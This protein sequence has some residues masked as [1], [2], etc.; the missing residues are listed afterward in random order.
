M[1]IAAIQLV[2]VIVAH[3]DDETL[4]A[5]GTILKHPLWNCF[6]VCLCRKNDANRAP[7]FFRAIKLLGAKGIMGNL[8]DG[9]KQTP[10]PEEKIEQLIMDLL[11]PIHFNLILTHNPTGEYTKHL[12]HEEVSRA[13]I[14]LWNSNKI[15]ANELMTFAYEDGNKQYYPRPV[16][17]AT[18]HET[19]TQE[20]FQRKYDLI[21]KIYR[22]RKEGWEAKTCPREESFWLF[23]KPFEA[24]QWLD[25]GGMV[26][27]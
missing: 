7:K 23:K 8:N 22:F 17:N 27:K 20:I 4:W 11:P 9:P 10:I 18:I 6:V 12:R 2:A 5:G 24:L 1:N 13:V 16:A 15:S 26:K 3:P 14:H 19:L 25:N 21:S